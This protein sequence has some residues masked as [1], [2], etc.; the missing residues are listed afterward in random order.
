[1]IKRVLWVLWIGALLLAGCGGGQTTASPTVTPTIADHRALIRQAEE[2]YW[3]GNFAEAFADAQA[4]VRA[5][6]QDATAWQWVQRSAVALAADDYLSHLP[7]DRYR[8]TPAEFI[9]NRV[10]GAVYT[11]VDVREPDE[12]AAGHIEGAIN[13]PLRELTQHLGELP[14]NTSA[15]IVVYCHSARRSVHALVVLRELGYRRVYNLKGGYEAYEE[16]RSTHPEPTPGPTPTFDPAR[17]PDQ[18][19]GC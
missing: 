5:A 18:D 13:I 4:A 14:A 7:A 15:P 2:A 6:P 12:Y 11:I 8:I 1:M 9:A 3:A 16:Y 19:G 10:N 17:D